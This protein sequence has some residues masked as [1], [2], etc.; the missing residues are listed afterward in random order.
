MTVFFNNKQRPIYE[1]PV[2]QNYYILNAQG[3]RRLSK[4]KVGFILNKG[5]PRAVTSGNIPNIPVNLRH[6]KISSVNVTNALLEAQKALGACKSQRT[7][8]A[9]AS[10]A[11]QTA[12]VTNNQN[13]IKNAANIAVNHSKNNPNA[14]SAQSANAGFMGA[15]AVAG[16]T[17]LPLAAGM[18]NVSP[19]KQEKVS[20]A[21]NNAVVKAGNNSPNVVNAATKAAVQTLSGNLSQVKENIA[22]IK[23]SQAAA[24]AAAKHGNGANA[25]NAASQAAIIVAQSP[26]ATPAKIE[27]AANAAA[28]AVASGANTP[29]VAAANAAAAANANKPTAAVN[30]AAKMNTK[31]N[32]NKL[33][34]E[35]NTNRAKAFKKF[36][37]KAHPNKGGNTN[38]F[39][40]VSG[41]YTTHY[42]NVQEANVAAKQA[43][44]NAKAAANAAKAEA[45]KAAANAAAKAAENAAKANKEAANKAAAN[46]A[47]V[48]AAAKAQA[49]AN[50]AA[51]AQAN[52]NAAAK[53]QANANAAAKAQAN[54]NAAAANA[55]AKAKANKE[56]ANAAAKA[57]QNA[58]NK[59]AANAAEAAKTK[60]AENKATANAAAKAAQ[61][62]AN[63][64]AA[65]AKAANKLA[66]NALPGTGLF[67]AK[68]AN[69]KAANAKAAN[70]KENEFQNSHEI[71]PHTT[72]NNFLQNYKIVGYP[73]N[74]MIN[75]TANKS[76]NFAR[77]FLSS[78]LSAGRNK[79]Q[80]ITPYG[81]KYP[82]KHPWANML[83]N[84]NAYN[85]TN[86]QKNMIRRINIALA[87]QPSVSAFGGKRNAVNFNISGLSRTNAIKKQKNYLKKRNNNAAAA[88]ANNNAASAAS[89]KN[90][91][92]TEPVNKNKGVKEMLAAGGYA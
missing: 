91:K 85:L 21:V 40:K 19:A 55:A 46:A 57:A 35:Y 60:N 68:A 54:A 1:D 59:A 8:N 77:R 47:A 37:L 27:K 84:I 72:M 34:N 9:A 76:A 25:A 82:N 63:K 83:N 51:K 81:S 20:N 17:L 12:A 3:K 89:R 70:A 7:A 53:A 45:N 64:A 31:E 4:P 69:A 28:N 29:A 44:E 10:A 38:Y 87:A 90:N 33:L 58:A 49:N 92:K 26:N 88:K 80:Q 15:L 18:P 67:N 30:A 74:L 42:K 14:P 36:S 66:F 78:K 79:A 71:L 23:A 5:L 65:N 24:N 73:K 48:N 86:A 75:V 39:Q 16:K 56:A 22:M 11:L 32:L 41:L 62:A 52:A 6:K 2:K 13:K 50:A 61:E 43:N